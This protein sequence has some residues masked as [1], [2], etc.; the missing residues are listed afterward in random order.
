MK[1]LKNKRE[2]VLKASR[3][4][5]ARRAYYWNLLDE[6]LPE[7]Y[8]RELDFIEHAFSAH[9]TRPISQ[10]LD[11]A[12]G[13]GRHIHEL[14]KRGYECTGRDYTPE[15]IQIAKERAKREGL[16]VKLLQGD[17]TRLSYEDEFDAALAINVL[18][19]LPNDDDVLKCLSLIHR[20]LRLG[21]I[22]VCNIGNPFCEGKR[23]TSLKTIFEGLLIQEERTPDIHVTE[24]ARLVD[25]DA[26]YGVAWWQ[27]TSII[28]S[29][30]G[31]HV[32]RDR[33]HLRLFTYWDIMRYLQLAGFK[34]IKCYPDWKTNPPKKPKATQLVFISRKD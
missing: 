27:E 17:S 33:E 32:F 1:R 28:E 23:W 29:P 19:L 4:Y 34:E 11:V 7:R 12:C 30:D 20:A 18:H 5:Y 14:T 15:N 16:S 8:K 24:I 31:I 3:A 21:G 25:F 10:V 2:T 6:H 13:N 22:L 9:A 26:M